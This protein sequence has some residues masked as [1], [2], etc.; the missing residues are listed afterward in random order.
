MSI[1]SVL[2]N[3]ALLRASAGLHVTDEVVIDVSLRIEHESF[4]QRL[5]LVDEEHHH[6]GDQQRDESGIK[7]GAEILRHAGDIAVDGTVSL[8]QRLTDPA[9]G[10]D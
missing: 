5:Q 2:T 9:D 7:R 6:D 3:L 10:T 8:P 4:L 1:A